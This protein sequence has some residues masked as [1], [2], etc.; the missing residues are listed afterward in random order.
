M[1][2]DES[3]FD[4][5]R[6]PPSEGFRTSVWVGP[7]SALTFN[8]GFTGRRRPLFQPRPPLFAAKAFTKAL[9]A[10]RRVRARRRPGRRRAARRAA[11]GELELAGHGD[12]RRAA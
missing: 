9:R 12:A 10:P 7:L 11:A 4:G 1:I 8:R 5:L 6:G 3:A 2:G